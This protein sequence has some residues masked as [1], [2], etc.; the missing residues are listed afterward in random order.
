MIDTIDIRPATEAEVAWCADLMAGNDPWLRY[1][2][3]VEWSRNLLKWPGSSLFVAAA[4]DPIGF[5][6][7]H[8]KGF[9]GSAYIA[10]VAVEKEFRCQDVG[11]RLL[12]FAEKTFSASRYSYLCVSSFNRGALALYQRCG[13]VK[14][15]ELPDF[16]VDGYSEF[17]MCKRLR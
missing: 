6:L 10:A 12:E 2:C 4:E 5:V 3:S 17:L 1:R 14:V 13:Y 8:Q 16:I 15:G 11:R 9:L 7:L